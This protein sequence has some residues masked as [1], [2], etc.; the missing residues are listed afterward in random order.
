M[1]TLPPAWCVLPSD[2]RAATAAVG[3]RE[4][5]G[6]AASCS[7]RR[8][9]GVKSAARLTKAVRRRRLPAR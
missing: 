5:D 6:N 7:G 3:H 4:Q 9:G 2:S 8:D 1:A